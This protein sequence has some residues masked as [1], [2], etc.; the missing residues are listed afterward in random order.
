MEGRKIM[1]RVIRIDNDVY[2]NLKKMAEAF[3]D[4]PNTVIRKLLFFY[5]SSMN[6]NIKI[7]E[8]PRQSNRMRKGNLTIQKVYEEWLI[9]V[10]WNEF[11]GRANKV[12]ITK[13]TISNMQKRGL[14]KEVDFEKV[15][16]GET[17]AENKIAWGRNRLKEEG[18]ISLHSP[19]GVWELTEE[20][21]QKAKNIDPKT[22]QSS[23]VS[24]NIEPTISKDVH[25]QLKRSY[26]IGIEKQDTKKFKVEKGAIALSIR[27]SLSG[28]YLEKRQ[29]M[30]SRGLFRKVEKGYELIDDYEFDSKAQATNILLGVSESANRA[31]KKI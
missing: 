23:N 5:Q 19:A 22:N 24:E 28:A 29:E 16:T 8:K 17:R 2:E 12:D 10:L 30:E 7:T 31:W 25:W 11:K 13:A 14:L 9:Y 20:G 1:A 21:I 18:F 3:E 26:A 27:E 15:S 6:Q 4:T